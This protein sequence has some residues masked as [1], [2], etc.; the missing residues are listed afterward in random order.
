MEYGSV[1]PVL[2]SL[3]HRL[4]D[5]IVRRELDPVLL[6][7]VE[8]AL[9]RHHTRAIKVLANVIEREEQLVEGILA[10]RGEHEELDYFR[11]NGHTQE[12]QQSAYLR[13]VRILRVL[14]PALADECQ[15][16]R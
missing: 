12:R 1:G 13:L 3:A 5:M 11:G 4:R 16:N 2:D 7:A 9:D 10:M 6:G 8:W 14:D 15:L